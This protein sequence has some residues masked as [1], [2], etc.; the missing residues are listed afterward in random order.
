MGR[1]RSMTRKYG[2]IGVHVV[3][4]GVLLLV[5]G[6]FV[7][8]TGIAPLPEGSL[9]PAAPLQASRGKNKKPSGTYPV[10]ASKKPGTEVW[11]GRYRDSRGE[12]E[13]T[14]SLVRRETTLYGVW[15]LRTG[16]GG[17][18]QGTV[19]EDGTLSFRMENAAPECAGTFEGRAK[20]EKKVMSGV[21]AGKDCEGKVSDGRLDLGLR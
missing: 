9:D 10:D 15:Q 2:G 19:G 12:G 20:V 4:Y 3:R 21:Y 6:A 11:V 16:G 13:I 18:V 17:P 8:C 14:L 5:L 1:P 7:S